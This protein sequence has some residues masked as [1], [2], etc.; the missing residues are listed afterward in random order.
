MTVAE[1][2]SALLVHPDYEGQVKPDWFDPAFWGAR[3]APV[4]SGGR[5]N[6]W[7]LTPPD[8]PAMVLRWYRRGGLVA[9]LSRFSYVFAG[10]S[11]ARAFT[12]FR[13]LSTLFEHGLPVPRPVAARIQRHHGVLYRGAIITCMIDDAVPLADRFERLARSDWQTLGSVIRQFHD[14]GVFHAD[15]NCFNILL[16]GDRFYLIDFD[17]GRILPPAGSDRWKQATLRRLV[18]S[19]EKVAGETAVARVWEWVLQGYQ[20]SQSK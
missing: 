3:C 19:L 18:R 15:L 7:F 1:D 16:Q 12:E 17:K 5:G 10:L 13:L 11:Q 14:A 4:S 2:G 20:R 8:E 9:R 6:A